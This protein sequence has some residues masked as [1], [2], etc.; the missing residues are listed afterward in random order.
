M[1]RSVA[2]RDQGGQ[3]RQYVLDL[4]VVVDVG[5]VQFGVLFGKVHD[6]RAVGAARGVGV[7]APLL[8][9]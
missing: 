9:R 3:V 1:A 7:S 8:L 2:D 4:G 6:R 5:G